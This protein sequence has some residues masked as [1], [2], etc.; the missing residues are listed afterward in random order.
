MVQAPQASGSARRVM[1]EALARTKG[2]KIKFET[3]RQA[4]TFRFACYNVRKIE[5]QKSK[6][7]FE[8]DDP[9][10]NTSMFDCLS[11]TLVKNESTGEMSD[12]F[13]GETVPFDAL[14]ED[15]ET[16]EDVELY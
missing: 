12:L 2:I 14:I 7:I 13:I 3:E 6:S 1:E 16:G 15:V 8:K 5:R 4:H 10:Y 9:S 11:L